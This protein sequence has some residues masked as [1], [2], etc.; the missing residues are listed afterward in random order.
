M[1]LSDVAHFLS[2]GTPKKDKL[3]YWNGSIP[4]FS[5]S[6]MNER[7]LSESKLRITESGLANGSRLAPKGATLLLVRGSGLFNYIPICYADRDVA[8]NQDVKAILP[9]DGIDSLFLHY[10]VEMHR[11]QLSNNIDVTGIGAGKFDTDLLKKL[12][13]P[14]VP[15]ENQAE[16]GRLAE[17]FDRKIELNRRMNATLERQAQAIFRDWFVDF[18]PVRRKMALRAADGSKGAGGKAAG[19]NGADAQHAVAVMGGLIQN[20]EKATQIAALFPDTMG[21]EGL[22]LG[23]EEGTLDQLAKSIGDTVDPTSIDPTTP[24][25]G[26][27]HM[28]RKSI[29]LDDWGVAGS[30]SSNKARFKT[31]QILFGKLRPY[32]HKVGIAPVDG[33]SSTDIVIIDG[34]RIADRALVA[35]CVSSTEFVAFTDQGSSGTKMPRTSWTLM[36]RYPFVVAPENIRDAFS[37]ICTPLHAKIMQSVEENQTLAETRDYLLPRLMSGK[38][39]VADAE[40]VEA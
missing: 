36:K 12:S 2:G 39:R 22:P 38:V 24:Y 23:W 17:S 33:V 37:E 10:A 30:V 32:F 28:P 18:G 6:N 27:E 13:F 5:A 14:D 25:I 31:G 35:S 26:L 11:T 19:G 21:N 1:Q 29:M 9:K 8:F 34:K 20:P 3:S 40:G 7:F 4:W 15:K 16:I